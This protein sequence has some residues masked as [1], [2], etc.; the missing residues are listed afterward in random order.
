MKRAFSILACAAFVSA[1][2]VPAVRAAGQEKTLRGAVVDL[3]C[4]ADGKNAPDHADCALRCAKRGQPLGVS[5][6][7]GVYV[8]TGTFADD[9]NAKL[10]D[11]VSKT[12]DV[13]G[14][15]TV[16]KDGK[17]TIDVTSIAIAK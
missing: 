13:K 6:A 12:V 8:I 2:A 14:T 15:V 5:A 9:K 17:K 4:D 1:L 10:V 11:F 7:D 16:D 3:D